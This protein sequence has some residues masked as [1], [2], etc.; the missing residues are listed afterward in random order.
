MTQIKLI[1]TYRVTVTDEEL[2]FI[3]G[4]AHDRE[5]ALVELSRTVLVEVEVRSA[6][7]KFDVGDFG[8]SWGQVAYD[9]KY[10]CLDGTSQIFI[11]RPF[12]R[13]SA[14]DFRVCFYLHVFEAG[15]T[16]T[17]PY[18]DLETGAIAPMPDRLAEICV[19]QH[20]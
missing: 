1:G 6:D 10:F 3:L 7:S 19:Y 8:L 17:S 15:D 18:G 12:D 14:S 16:I 2:E 20:P 9:E 11:E 13:P 5:T 4:I